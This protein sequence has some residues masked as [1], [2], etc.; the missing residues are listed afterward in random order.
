MTNLGAENESEM[1]LGAEAQIC[2]SCPLFNDFCCPVPSVTFIW[3]AQYT[4]K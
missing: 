3:R 2:V 4:F 1:E